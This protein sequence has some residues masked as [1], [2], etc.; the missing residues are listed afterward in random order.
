MREQGETERKKG[1][2]TGAKGQGVSPRG[3][4][5]FDCLIRNSLTCPSTTRSEW[6]DSSTERRLFDFLR[7]ALFLLFGQA[8]PA[9]RAPSL[10]LTQGNEDDR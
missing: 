9:E 7:E 10:T 3:C 1:W 2:E 6:R 8:P 4:L 5:L